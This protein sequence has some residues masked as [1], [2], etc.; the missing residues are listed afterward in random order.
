[1]VELAAGRGEEVA[2]VSAS[3]SPSSFPGA[4]M[5]IAADEEVVERSPGCPCCAVRHDLVRVL[6]NLGERRH[7]P[8]RIIVETSA[9]ADVATLEQTLMAHPALRRVVTLDGVGHHRGRG[10]GRPA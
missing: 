1:M 7:R 10:A 4:Q 8:A 6:R 9:V 3:L 5:V 2:V